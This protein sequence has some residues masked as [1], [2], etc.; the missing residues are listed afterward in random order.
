MKREY[1]KILA[2][3]TSF[4]IG[5]PAFC[6]AKAESVDDILEAVAIAE[7]AGKP[8]VTI[9]RGSN[10]LISDK[11]FDGVLLNLGEDFNY[12]KINDNGSVKAGA[13]LSLSRLVKECPVAGLA[14]CEFLAGIPGSLG[15]AIF[16]NAGVRDAENPAELKEI[17]DI[18]L[19]IEVVDLI[20]KKIKRLGKE[21][22]GFSYRSSGLF[23]KC[24][25]SADIKLQKGEKGVVEDRVSSF[26]KKRSWIGKLG[27]S[28]AGSIFKNPANDKPAGRLIEECGLKGKRLGNAEISGAHANFIVNRGAAASEDILGLIDLAKKSVRDRFNIELELEIKVI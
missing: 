20:D 11:G 17:K 5:G 3:Y 25:I 4:G 6:W 7:K 2:G 16:M 15:G 24:V 9:G 28:T 8:L 22:I 1:G 10:I 19:S 14:G 27:F 21:E 18:V 23:G 13:G 12:I 26:M